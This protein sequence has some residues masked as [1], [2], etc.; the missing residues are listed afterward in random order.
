MCR[1]NGRETESNGIGWELFKNYIIA[2]DKFQPDYYLYENVA[3]MSR[4]IKQEIT[5]A[6]GVEPININGALT[7]AAERDRYYWTNIT[8][9]ELPKDKGLV[10]K[11]ILEPTVD[12]KY[13]Y[14]YPLLNVDLSKQVCAIMDY[15]NNEMHQRIFNPCFKV[16]TLT[17]CGGGN[18]QKKVLVNGRARKLTPTEYERCM[19]LPDGYT[20]AVAE[21][22]RYSGCGNGWDAEVIIHI[23]K[24]A[25]IPTEKPIAVLSMYDGIGT[26]RYVLNKM[27]HKNVTYYAYEIDTNAI[28]VAKSNYQDIVQLGD[29]FQVR[30]DNWHLP[31]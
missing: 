29:A 22:H 10:L 19:N 8:G 13:F 17:T 27:G 1:P 12:E 30:D 7:S 16:H 21:T 28:K 3:S 15:K 18:T 25:N 4:D 6:L 11:D 9:I 14:N 2:K 5:N 31:V 23:L 20:N 24:H 26:G